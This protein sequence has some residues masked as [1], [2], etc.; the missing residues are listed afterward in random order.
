MKI[1]KTFSFMSSMALTKW[2]LAGYFLFLSTKY[3]LWADDFS[4]INHYDAKGFIGGIGGY[5][6][7]WMGNLAIVVY[8][9]LAIYLIGDRK[10]FFELV[11]SLFFVLFAWSL[12]VLAAKRVPKGALDHSIFLLTG[13]LLLYLP[14]AS[15]EIYFWHTGATGYLW[16]ISIAAWLLT[17]MR[18]Y[19]DGGVLSRSLILLAL[20]LVAL[21]GTQV[22]IMFLTIAGFLLIR[23]YQR[24]QQLTRWEWST[25]AMYIFFFLINVLSPGNKVRASVLGVD[26]SFYDLSSLYF[27]RTINSLVGH[28]VEINPQIILL[29]GFVFAL[30]L[31]VRVMRKTFMYDH[32]SGLPIVSAL[33]MFLGLFIFHQVAT[34]WLVIEGRVAAA[35]EILMVFA[36][37][38]YI[39]RLRDDLT[40]T[41]GA[42]FIWGMV[43]GSFSFYVYF[44]SVNLK[45]Q[46]QYI[47]DIQVQRLATIKASL[48]VDGVIK[49]YPLRIPGA[50]EK[51]LDVYSKRLLFVSDITPNVSDWR[52]SNFQVYHGL[53]CRVVIE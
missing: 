8:Q 2:V 38:Y 16:S 50:M 51:V 26:K 52:N 46:L 33:V 28:F 41:R 36:I 4:I 31:S 23:Q 25:G 53:N 49:T 18:S 15:G 9:Y 21:G 47:N 5:Y 7:G 22:A 45:Y 10:Y 37:V 42:I 19:N 44:S 39:C 35:F 3:S 40:E 48:C 14:A 27:D 34:P 17:K 1:S 13:L 11:N 20:M 24:E 43:L 30:C 32:K 29:L 12:Y 6:F